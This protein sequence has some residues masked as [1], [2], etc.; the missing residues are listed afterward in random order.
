[1]HVLS[2]MLLAYCLGNINFPTG[3]PF[4][5]NP[6]NLNT[7]S[8]G[9]YRETLCRRCVLFENLDDSAKK[10]CFSV[11]SLNCIY[12]PQNKRSGLSESD[13]RHAKN[14]TGE[15]IET[16]VDTL[17]TQFVC[18]GIWVAVYGSLKFP[19]NVH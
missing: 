6:G 11:V 5:G 7:L 15:F 12:F 2:I 1:M 9:M 3:F 16:T 8:R 17:L 4:H 14:V 10:N 19:S 13:S 18:C